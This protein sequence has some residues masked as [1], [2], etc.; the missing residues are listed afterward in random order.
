[1]YVSIGMK[2][3]DLGIY[4]AY[5]KK[6]KKKCAS[7]RELQAQKRNGDAVSEFSRIL[8]RVKCR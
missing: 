2:A 5:E 3:G 1:M 6:L 7:K 8:S 4:E